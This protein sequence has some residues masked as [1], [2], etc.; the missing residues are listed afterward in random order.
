MHVRNGDV[1]IATK[2]WGGD[3]I[4]MLLTH[5]AFFFKETL[6]GLVPRL[7]PTFRVITFDMRAHGAS[8]DGPWEWPL[9]TGDVEAVRRAYDIEHPV[10]A[11][12]S[13]GGMVAAMYAADYPVC[14]A[15]INIDGQGRGKPSQ[16]AGMTEA[17]V[18]DGW[19][20][21]DAEEAK[22]LA[23]LNKPRMAEMLDA[24]ERL[25]MFGIWRAT[26][27]PLQIF[28]CVAYDPMYAA[29]GE[30]IVALMTAYR[31]GLQREFAALAEEIP[32]VHITTLDKTHIT[33]VSE[34]E[35]TAEKMATFVTNYS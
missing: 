30:R 18:L 10:V 12:H 5:G 6:E 7:Q 13:L 22:M 15:A 34:P 33:V 32:T 8:G 17:E 21:L 26:P 29:R 24:I 19:A 27:C 1:E 35:A 16:Y 3:G 14:R 25:D 23:S 28:N 11:G 20:L 4:P 31:E 2:D 9:V